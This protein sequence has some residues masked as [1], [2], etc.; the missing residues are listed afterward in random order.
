MY[1]ALKSN[2]IVRYERDV[3]MAYGPQSGNLK[4]IFLRKNNLASPLM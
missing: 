4:Y 2:P 1:C 3:G